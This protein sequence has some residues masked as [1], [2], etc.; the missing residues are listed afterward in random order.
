LDAVGN[1]GAAVYTGGA[2]PEAVGGTSLSSPLALGVWARLMT[3]TDNKLGFAGPRLYG[4]Y[5]TPSL[6]DVTQGN[7]GPYEATPGWDFATGLGT[8]DVGE[9]RLV[10]KQLVKKPV[11]ATVP[12]PACTSFTDSAGDSHPLATSGNVDSLD[13]LAGGLSSDVGNNTLTAVLRVRRLDSG[14]AGT[15]QVV[16]GG[17]V[18]FLKF[19]GAD[20]TTHWLRATF[21]AL[22]NRT[23]PQPPDPN[24]PGW[25]FSYGHIEQVGSVSNHV[26]DGSAT[27]TV[28]FEDGVISM[29][30][31]LDKLGFADGSVISGPF[32]ESYELAGAGG[33]G[34]LE[35]ADSTKTGSSYT[36]GVN[37]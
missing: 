1:T 20:G 6:H 32:G 28:D 7:T 22:A 27:G 24:Y 2:S 14:P 12:S 10:A 18:W 37:C 5:S 19:A 36:V 8:F 31:P 34:F 3:T 15:P 35:A 26:A 16:G 13:I 30:A 33:T 25:T 21:P 11:P 9:A 29:V 17:D 23:D 4:M